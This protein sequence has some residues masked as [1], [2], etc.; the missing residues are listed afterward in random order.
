MKSVSVFKQLTY[1]SVSTPTPYRWANESRVLPDRTAWTVQS[2]GGMHAPGVTTA[3]CSDSTG[4]LAGTVATKGT[5][6]GKGCIA[7]A[8]GKGDGDIVWTVVEGSG[9]MPTA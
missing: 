3:A 2:A 8:V 9:V 1:I 4:G 6:L 5:G 7:S